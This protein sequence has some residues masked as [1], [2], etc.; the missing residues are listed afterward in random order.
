[1]IEAYLRALRAV[2]TDID[3]VV[4]DDNSPDGTAELATT[5]AAELGGVE[6]LRR[7]EKAGL[8]SAY[9]AGFRTVLGRRPP[10][11]VV[12]SMDADL[13]HDPAVIP[14]MLRQIEEGADAVIGSRYV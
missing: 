14:T 5:L 7:T 6:V 1:N 4:V 9:R 12:I 10:Y 3:V 13:S 11:D 2:S 8:G